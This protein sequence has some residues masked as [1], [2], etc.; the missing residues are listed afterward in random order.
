MSIG[1]GF[2]VSLGL[3]FVL[4]LVLF[5]LGVNTWYAIVAC[6]ALGLVLGLTVKPGGES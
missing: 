3:N 1:N 5:A 4:A 2:L 6:S